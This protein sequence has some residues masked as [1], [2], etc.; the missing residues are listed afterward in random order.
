MIDRVVNTWPLFSF[1]SRE[2]VAAI[3]LASTWARAL[4]PCATAMWRNLEVEQKQWRLIYTYTWLGFIGHCRQELLVGKCHHRVE[5]K[6]S[7]RPTIRISL[8]FNIKC[9]HWLNYSG[10]FGTV[11]MTHLF[12]ENSRSTSSTMCR[13]VTR[14][15]LVDLLFSLNVQPLESGVTWLTGE[16]PAELSGIHTC[17]R[18]RPASS[19][20]RGPFRPF[21]GLPGVSATGRTSSCRRRVETTGHLSVPSIARVASTGHRWAKTGH[22]P[23]PNTAHVV[24]GGH[25][26]GLSPSQIQVDD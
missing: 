7:F 22:W 19:G 17:P 15:E 5:Y 8:Q 12:A 18:L 14:C 11:L 9:Q 23:A 20:P 3:L 16:G 2:P 6:W 10:R 1:T 25:R 13:V 24:V 4:F 21:S 26:L